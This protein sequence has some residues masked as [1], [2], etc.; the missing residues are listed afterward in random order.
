MSIE[1]DQ[2]QELLAALGEH[3]RAL[4]ADHVALVVCGGTAMNALGFV[5]RAT[6]DV[7]VVAL[8]ETGS[9]GVY[10]LCQA[11]PLP[12]SVLEARS[13]VSAD[14]N[15]AENWLNDGP[16]SLLHFGLPSGCEQR[17]IAVSFG[18]H[19]TVHYLS[20]VDLICLKLYA[21][22]DSGA[23]RH[24]Q[25]LR[26]LAPNLD[27]WRTATTWV[28]THNEPEGFLPLLKQALTR[29]GAGDVAD[30]LG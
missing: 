19:L 6:Q 11:A 14:Y 7:D 15:I 22:A 26:A 1:P 5:K 12:P 25:D 17:L 20:R 13:R 2:F 4:G 24:A 30:E 21:W 29:L 28:M 27:E 8:L 23:I 3:L 9:A 18:S 16:A 10:R